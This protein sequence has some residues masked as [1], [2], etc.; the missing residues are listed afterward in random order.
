MN[1]RTIR[2]FPKVS[3]RHEKMDL[4]VMRE[5]TED[6]YIGLATTPLRRQSSSQRD[7]QPPELPNTLSILPENTV[8][9]V[10]LVFTRQTFSTTQMA[11]SYVVS[12]KL[13]TITQAFMPTI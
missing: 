1:P 7:L 5:V 9:S 6:V 4:V 12:T 8:E 10:S 11:S 13:P 3:E 2:G